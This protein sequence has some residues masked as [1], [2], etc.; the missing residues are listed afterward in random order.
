MTSR[1][2]TPTDAARGNEGGELITSLPFGNEIGMRLHQAEAGVAVLSVPY[3]ER[4]VGNP[5]DRS[6]PCSARPGSSWVRSPSSTVS[7]KTRARRRRG[8]GG[9]SER[10]L[11]ALAHNAVG[12]KSVSTV[13]QRG[14][15]VLPALKVRAALVRV[16]HKNIAGG[17]ATGPAPDTLQPTTI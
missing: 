11:R 5:A 2:D 12:A 15:Y 16:M 1:D 7:Y 13:K 14:K 17:G 8:T 4:L 10:Y 6:T 9:V 3:D